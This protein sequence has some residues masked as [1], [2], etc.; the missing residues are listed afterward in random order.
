VLDWNGIVQDISQ[1]RSSPCVMHSC[2]P[3]SG[4]CI[5]QAFRV[6]CGNATYF[7]KTLRQQPD[8]PARVDMFSAEA[9]GLQ[10]IRQ[11]GAIA[12]P[13][14]VCW[15]MCGDYA[16]LAMEYVQFG[17]GSRVSAALLGERLAAMHRTTRP[18]FGWHRANTIGAT[19]QLN[20]Y[21]DDWI[22]FFSQYRL[23]V[24]FELAA[25]NG[26]GKLARLGERL[27]AALPDFF[28]SYTPQASLL[29]GDLWS[30]NYA[31]DTQGQPVLF[32]PAVYYGDREADLAMTELFGGFPAAFYH[33]YHATWPLDAG[34]R[35]RKNLYNLYH[36]VNHY[37]LFGGSYLGQ[38]ERMVANLL[39]ELGHC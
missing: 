3:V 14:P 23:G 28:P 21:T 25:R 4:G 15:G 2:T 1:Q 8:A 19:P 5:N 6:E 36:I 11:T 29:H 17:P 32:D 10:E 13:Q 12:A 16:Y 31:L 24:Q 20:P 22:E 38:A 33:A 7:V 18:Q 37:N 9:D 27:L 30:G 39:A 35:T 26:G 34:Y